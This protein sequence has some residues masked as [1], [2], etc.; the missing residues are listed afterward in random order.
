MTSYT[1][2]PEDQS[3]ALAP[4]PLPRVAFMSILVL[5][6]TSSGSA[7][8]SAHKP[9]PNAV[10]PPKTQPA[11]PSP[12][13]AASEPTVASKLSAAEILQK[14]SQVP[15][16]TGSK[17]LNPHAATVGAAQSNVVAT[18]KN[19]MEVATSE[20]AQI[21]AASSSPQGSGLGQGKGPAAGVSRSLDHASSTMIAPSTLPPGPLKNPPQVQ[22][23]PAPCQQGKVAL[24]TINGAAPQ[25]IVFTPDQQY[26]LYTLKGCHFGSQQ[27]QLFIIGNFKGNKLPLNIVYWADGQI[28]A[29][30]DPNLTGEP[31][32]SNKVK[33][34]LACTDGQ[35][36]EIDGTSFYAARESITM[37]KIPQTWATLGVVKDVS[38][39]PLE[40][41]Y[42][43][44]GNYSSATVERASSDRFS[45]GQDYYD[46][47]H[48][49][50]QFSVD[51]ML[52]GYVT[53][54]SGCPANN[55]TNTI[56]VDGVTSAQWDGNGI[57]VGL[58]GITCHN[59][60]TGDYAF[61]YYT[62]QVQATGPRGVDPT[63]P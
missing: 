20:R 51:S 6:L 23:L 61:S 7:Q 46:L 36:V 10:Q 26:N 9:V 29:S 27:G 52:L 62:L 38:G 3:R 39:A 30:M 18:L 21:L 14:I 15:K 45:G 55:G 50:S 13:P 59:A 34:F 11:S 41:Y 31:D 24:F 60:S 5:L 32:E 49:N 44:G 19:Q 42:Q 40:P 48:V 53:A 12:Q 1:K 16:T 43:T 22:A 57:R 4:F 25:A 17:I 8:S 56:Y 58:G 63:Q 37:A 28:I 33:F 47:S 35:Q 54:Q 2:R